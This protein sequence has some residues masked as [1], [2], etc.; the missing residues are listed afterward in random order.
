MNL[1]N[2]SI[3]ILLIEDDEVDIKNIKYGFKD[4]NIKNNLIIVNNGVDA[5]NVLYGRNGEKVL[6]PKPKIIILDINMPK[7]NGFEFLKNIQS[8][9]N[10]SN[11]PVLI[12][13]TSEAEQDKQFAQK[14]KTA[15]Y[16]PKPLNFKNFLL[17]YK[18]IIENK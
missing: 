11:I 14:F 6:T 7:M 3:N 16:F 9:E 13:T 2:K 4:F 10:F 15:G 17:V 1:S 12:V 8:D 18:R 5:L